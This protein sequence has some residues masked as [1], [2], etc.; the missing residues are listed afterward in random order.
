[1]RCLIFSALLLL[2][3]SL[4]VVSADTKLDDDEWDVARDVGSKT[5]YYPQQDY[6]T[7]H[8]PP[9]GCQAVHYNLLARH[10]SRRPGGKDIAAFEK[11]ERLIDKYDDVDRACI[12]HPIF[13]SFF[14][15]AHI[16]LYN[17]AL[18]CEHLW[19]LKSL[20]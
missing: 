4:L 12:S 15:P 1:M 17:S 20:F 14:Q 8:P 10:G 19:F 7:Y 11:M 2:C 6:H 9:K 13:N 3:A 16:F 18:C 5:P